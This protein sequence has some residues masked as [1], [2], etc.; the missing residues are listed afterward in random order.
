MIDL[1]VHSHY[2]DG[3]CSPK[4]LVEYAAT[5]G[6]TAFALTDHDTIAGLD[7]A[8]A[9][10]R[11]FCE[12]C[13]QTS[14]INPV[15]VV[16]G[17]E[18]STEYNGRDVH[19]IGLFI[20]YQDIVFQNQ[21]H[22]FMSA[23]EERN[24]KMCARFEER[25]ISIPITELKASAPGAV[26]TRAHYAQYLLDRGYVKSHKEAF[27]RYLGDHAPC[28]VPRDK[29]SPEQAISLIRATHGIPVLAHPVLYHMS[30]AELEALVGRLKEAGLMAIEAIY[31]TYSSSDT[32]QMQVIAKK[33]DLLLSG[34]SDFHGSTKSGLQFGTGYG[35]L[36]IHED[37]LDKLRAARPK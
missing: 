16:P 2:S 26:I 28:F 35:S 20:D 11:V 36:Y 31:S 6:I 18:L 24:I 7:E 29:V 4:E 22:T 23:R 14:G 25:G 33:Y 12:K 34:G 15:E 3:S 32:R 5:H 37:I 27:E 10:A 9:H 30:N 19:I 1:H 13:G 8:I 17:V 21:I